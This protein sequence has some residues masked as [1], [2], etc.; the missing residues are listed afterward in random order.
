MIFYMG[1]LIDT[2]IN[3]K[4]QYV[5]SVKRRLPSKDEEDKEEVPLFLVTKGRPSGGAAVKV[6]HE[7]QTYAIPRANAGRSMSVMS[8]VS[9]IFSLHREAEELPTTPTV[10]VIGQ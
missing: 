1:E 7:G 4:S 3:S 5:P 6:S 8:L 2:Q 9:L 10:K